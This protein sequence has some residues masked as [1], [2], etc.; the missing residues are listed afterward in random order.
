MAYSNLNPLDWST[1]QPHVDALLA[2][3]LSLDN[4][5]AW[6]QGWSDLT[7]VL[8][9]TYTQ[10][11]REVSENT[12]DKEAEKRFLVLVEQIL[13]QAK[14]ADQAL[15]NKL[16]AVE[17]YT[18][19]NDTVM[20]MK[21]FRTEASIFRKENVPLQ[22][23]LMK[24]ANEYEKIVGGMT[25]EWEGRQETMPQARLHLRE[26]DRATR[27]KAWRLMMARFAA[28]RDRLN[29][30]YLQML[31]LRRQV[32]KNA[33]FDN[34][35]DY[36]WK[37]LN[38]FDY[39]PDDCFTFHDTLEREVVPLARQLY[40]QQAEQLGL[41]TLRPW[42]TDADPHGEPLHPFEDAAELEEGG[43]RIF[44]QVDPVLAEHFAAMRNGYLD[45]ASRPHKAPGGFC[46]GFPVSRKPYIFM[47][48]VGTHRDV[49][50]L[51]H[52]GGHAFHF[53]ESLRQPLI[54]NYEAP[55]EFCEVASMAMELLSA[56]HLERS[57][58]G[59]Y[60]E[61]DA[62]RAYAKQLRDIVLFLPYMAVVDAFQ[63]WVYVDAPENVT[64]AAL[65]RVWSELW[66]RFMAG[67]DYS[68]LQAE[69]ESGWQRKEHIFSS[70]FYYIE[71]GLAQLGALQVWRNALR[72]Q[73]M[74]VADYRAA[75]ALGATRPLPELFSAAGATFA[76]DR[77][78]VGE[79]MALIFEKLA[80]LEA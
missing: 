70:P 33:S 41:D 52:E 77:R 47:N 24:L 23:E 10:I 9:E 36:Q 30:L 53:M 19:S 61:A 44:Q 76:F 35:R 73:A 79:L 55:I 62:R 65:D 26:T 28:E 7:T 39:T 3:D 72:N 14:I 13:P 8:R 69:K 25:I 29:E 46:R 27:E 67:I 74:A 1:I 5:E 75:L 11:Y 60:D 12:A 18:P 45:L 6:L 42:D 43:Y 32:A 64:A 48:A 59:F 4:V 40:A 51:L 49:N 71:Y 56:P 2:T 50:T 68:S 31:S 54:W 37:A 15:K 57:K 16:L 66:D 58:G 21:R 22:S 63:H 38:R 78:T 34:Y 17:D 20:M 80:E